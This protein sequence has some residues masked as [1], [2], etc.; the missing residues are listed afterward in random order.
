MT[1]GK[2]TTNTLRKV[3]RR[4]EVLA[5]GL[6]DAEI[7]VLCTCDA[8]L[9]G[10]IGGSFQGWLV[11]DEISTLTISLLNYVS[12]LL[13]ANVKFILLGDFWQLPPVCDIWAGKEVK[14][15]GF[16]Y[17]FENKEFKLIN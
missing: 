17:I 4:D 9:V 12:T 15:N 10:L 5:D 6:L 8:G 11:I 7:F 14:N 2:D 1:G 16:Q 3:L 13:R